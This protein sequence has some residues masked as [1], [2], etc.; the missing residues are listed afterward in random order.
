MATN[1]RVLIIDEDL[2]SRVETRRAVQRARLELAGEVGFGTQA[3]TSARETRPDVMLIA[4]EEPVSRPLETA[5]ALA[6]VLP[7][8]PFIFYASLNEPEAVRRAVLYGARDYLLKPLQGQQVLEAVI[9][10]LEFE[11]KRHMRQAGQLVGAPVRGTVV[12]VAGAKG[13]IGKSILAVNL[14]LALHSKTRGRVVIVDADT[15][16]GDVA[17]MLDLGP[18]KTMSEL[19]RESGAIDRDRLGD[20]LVSIDKGLEVLAGPREDDNVWELAGPEAAGKIVDL[21]SLSHDFV[22]VDT[23]GAMDAY[24]KSVVEASTLV[25]LVTTGEVSSV[26]DT[27]AG[28]SRLKSWGVPDEKVKVV[29]N[30]G[31]RAEGF[32]VSD[33]EKVLGRPVFWEMPRDKEVGRSVQLGRPVVVDKPKSAIARNIF[34]LAEAI[35]GNVRE[36]AA[37]QGTAR[38]GLFARFRGATGQPS[39]SGGGEP[40]AVEV[41]EGK[42]T[43]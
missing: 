38:R 33:L 24:V 11:E 19:L 42:V 10:A 16:F 6:N 41:V 36:A 27:K 29:L 4:V 34:A 32:Q 15:Q 1:P 7:Q 26:R 39:E 3:V 12:T 18:H 31:A 8:T 37:L 2:D 43:T 13:G 28:L 20:Y 14:A 25:L 30:R 21:L 17:T 5:E 35:G 9:R 22:I 23:S 40:A